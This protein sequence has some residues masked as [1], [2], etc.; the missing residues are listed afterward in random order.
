M[1]EFQMEFNYALERR[2][3]EKQ[4][5]L[6]QKQ[7]REAGMDDASIDQ[8]YKFD[9]L[10]FN[11]ERRYIRHQA[12]LPDDMTVCNF[13]CSDA[14]PHVEKILPSSG[15]LN[16]SPSDRRW[17]IDEIEDEELLRKLMTLSDADIELLTALVFEG[18]TQSEFAWAKGTN[19]KSV[20]RQLSQISKILRKPV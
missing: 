4:W 9:L 14:E 13:P 16:V 6:L 3:F 8:I 5:K 17:W 19:Q 10:W 1:E 2:K 12:D 15:P 11:S 20:S 7:Y 18:K